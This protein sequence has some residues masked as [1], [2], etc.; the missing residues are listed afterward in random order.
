M[1]SIDTKKVAIILLNYNGILTTFRNKSILLSCIHYL[2]KTRYNNYK[3]IIVDNGSTDQSLF[4]IG[5]YNDID[6][7]KI[8]KNV[9]NFSVANNIGMKYAKEKYNS[10]YFLLIS[11]DV[12]T[13]NPLW[14]KKLIAVA[15]KQKAGIVGCKLVYPTGR[16]Q[17]AGMS[18]SYIARNI[19]RGEEDCNQYNYIKEVDGVTFALVLIKNKVINNVG[20][21]DENFHMGYEDVDYCLRVRKEGYKIIYDGNVN[22]VH[23]EGYTLTNSKYPRRQMLTF[24]NGQMNYIYFALKW[25]NVLDKIKALSVYVLGAFITTEGADKKKSFKNIRI[26]EQPMRRL[27]L[28]LIALYEVKRLVSKNHSDMHN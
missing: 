14:L 27:Y 26:K 21:L 9:P 25:L 10:D 19:G 28:S 3:I 2:K 15:E 12:F 8:E 23:L 11:N 13:I 24:Y 1:R 7:I 5:K 16:I 20:F 22:N 6:I 18:I 4:K 17:H